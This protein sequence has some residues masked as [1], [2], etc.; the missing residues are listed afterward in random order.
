MSKLNK[1]KEDTRFDPT[2]SLPG[3]MNAA[4]QEPLALLRRATLASLLWENLAYESGNDNV[5][6]IQQ[7]VPQVNAQ[8]VANL[9]IECRE[10]QKLRHTP[11]FIVREM[12][13]YPEHKKHV[14]RVLENIVTRPDM[15]TDFVALYWKDGK[16]PLPSS[17]KRAFANCFTKFSEFQLARYKQQDKLISLR[18]V[19]F[20][21]HPTP[22]T[23]EQGKTF[24]Q[25]ADK[26]LTPVDTWEVNLSASQNKTQTWE[27]L[28]AENKVG[29]L[30]LLR[31]LN[32]LEAAN[33]PTSVVKRAL[34]NIKSEWL[35]PL[36]FFA[37]YKA[38][39]KY[40][41]EIEEAM[42]RVLGSVDK[43]PGTTVVVVDC[44][45]SMASTISGKSTFSRQDVANAL[46]MFAEA[47][48]ENCIIYATAGIDGKGEHSTKRVT[49]H[50]GFAVIDQLV[51]N[52]RTLGGGGIFTRQCLEF[53]KLD[54][55]SEL[56]DVTRVIVISDSQDCDRKNK[57][58]SPFAKYNYIIDVSA[59]SRG[60]NYKGVW[61]AEVSGWSE[62]FLDFIRVS[63]G[64][65]IGVEEPQ[66]ELQ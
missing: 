54:L 66:L 52:A 29:G 36:N 49:P 64:L 17:V 33:V 18:D 20:L 9:A 37:A 24:K 2:A 27:R 32:N 45:G 12:L 40:T 28:L 31:N 38:Q 39:P 6:N 23:D 44:S 60:V 30:A 3:G 55:G 59:H 65:N 8:D 53:I 42:L 1:K 15:M 25:L 43:L 56:D 57:T 4:T 22:K 35:L 51:Q 34:G 26:T 50:R 41:R 14:Q 61:T 47:Q 48:C 46:A 5:A 21:V 58:P 7:L 13:K 62:R 19:M 10:Q 11:L 63:E 16:I